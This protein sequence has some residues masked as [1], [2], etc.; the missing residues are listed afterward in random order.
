MVDRPTVGST[1]RYAADIG[2]GAAHADGDLHPD[3]HALDLPPDEEVTV[4]GH[5]D[6]RDLVL[7]AWT[8]RAGTPRVTSVD[9]DLFADRFVN[10]KE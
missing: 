8:D 6:D 2:L 9:P 10:V 4:A 3:M 7:L 5:D 1:Y